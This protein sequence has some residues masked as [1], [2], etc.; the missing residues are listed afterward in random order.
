MRKHVQALGLM[1][2]YQNDEEF[3][4]K[5]RMV[6]ALA[7]VPVKRLEDAVDQLSNYLPNQLH[8]L[9]DWFEDNY[10]GRANR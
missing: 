1:P 5:A 2:E 7:F 9:L 8:P 6:T 3:S 4:L 10:L